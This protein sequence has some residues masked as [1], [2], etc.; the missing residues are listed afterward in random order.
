M[1]VLAEAQDGTLAMPAARRQTVRA[2]AHAI[3]SGK[4]DLGPGADWDLARSAL[5]A[6]PGIGPWTIELVALRGLGDPDAFTPTD[7]GVRLAAAALGLPGSPAALTRRAA[8]WRPWRGYAVQYL[9]A[10]SEHAINH[11]PAA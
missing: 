10:T 6:V 2:L 7:L 8:P 1:A 9:W 3:A 11:L 4:V 5:G